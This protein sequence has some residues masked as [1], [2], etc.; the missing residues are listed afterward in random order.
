M[1]KPIF[2]VFHDPHQR[3]SRY[4]GNFFSDVGLQVVFTT[5]GS[6]TSSVEPVDWRTEKPLTKGSETSSVEPVLHVWRVPAQL[7]SSKDFNEGHRE[8]FASL[9]DRKVQ[10]QRHVCAQNVVGIARLK[11]STERAFRKRS[12]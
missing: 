12:V 7:P 11:L 3:I 8:V 6:E 4:I 5:K 1:N 10:G 9:N 2:G